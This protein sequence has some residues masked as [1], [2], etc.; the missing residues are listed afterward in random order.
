MPPRRA[1]AKQ[2]SPDQEQPQQKLTLIATTY[3]ELSMG[4]RYALI[5]DDDPLALRY[6]KRRS[7]S[8]VDHAS[9]LP[10]FT[11]D[12]FPKLSYQETS[13]KSLIEDV[14]NL[15]GSGTQRWRYDDLT[16]QLIV[17]LPQAPCNPSVV[18]RASS[19]TPSISGDESVDRPDREQAEEQ[20][21]PEGGEEKA[22]HTRIRWN[23]EM[24]K[25]L[26]TLLKKKTPLD[27]IVTA[28]SAIAGKDTS[29]NA[30][31]A[32]AHSLDL[33]KYLPKKG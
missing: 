6:A 9:D 10:V 2:V 27:E 25:K 4:Q 12:E 3:G 8:S 33:G 14:E 31:I 20:S 21:S 28:I 26:T 7:T 22:K 32:Q 18:V 13:I 29:L 15:F 11:A 17:G 16:K 1:S 19:S 5:G 24:R 23:D 30:I